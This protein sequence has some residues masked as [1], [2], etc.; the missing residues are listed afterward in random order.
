MAVKIRLARHGSKKRPFYYIVAANDFA[1]RDGDFLEKLGFYNPMAPKDS[2]D[3]LRLNE[4]ATKKWLAVGAQPT[5]RVAYLL[6]LLGVIEK[7]PARNNPQKAVV[8]KKRA[9]R[10]EKKAEK[11]AALSGE[12]A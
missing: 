12:A 6:A 4:E 1:P 11:A 7:R 2:P 3:R 9:E 8:G 10:A 5:D